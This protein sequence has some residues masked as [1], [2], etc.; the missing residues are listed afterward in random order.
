MPKGGFILAKNKNG[1]MSENLKYEIARE[2]GVSDTVA[3]E[4]WGAV[5]SRDCGRMVR[6]AIEIANRTSQ[7]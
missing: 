1:V 5:S 4:G 3:K 2:L 7:K 6:L